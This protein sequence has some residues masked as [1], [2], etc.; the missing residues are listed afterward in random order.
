MGAAEEIA[1]PYYHCIRC[2][3]ALRFS[4]VVTMGR[5]VNDTFYLSH[6]CWC[7]PNYLFERTFRLDH[8]ALRSLLGNFRPTLPYQ[9]ADAEALPLRGHQERSLAIF[10]WE[11]QQLESV[12]DFLTF[13]SRPHPAKPQAEQ[14][15][16]ESPA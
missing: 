14:A 1:S 15:P 7:T 8:A 16:P 3:R 9:A 6:H 10:R 4:D 2:R 5:V 13:A 11:C 12:E